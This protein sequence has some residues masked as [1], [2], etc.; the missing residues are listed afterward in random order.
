MRGKKVFDGSIEMARLR[1]VMRY[2]YKEL[3][4]VLEILMLVDCHHDSSS[5]CD[6]SPLRVS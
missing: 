4:A 2:R 5:D 3:D 1:A 6:G